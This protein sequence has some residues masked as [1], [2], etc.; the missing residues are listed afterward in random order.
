MSKDYT[1]LDKYKLCHRCE[2]A[3]VFP[4]RK[5]CPKCLEE[6]Q[7][8]AAAYRQTEEY[9]QNRAAYNARRSAKYY[10]RKDAGLCTVCGKPA[11][12]GGHYCY[13]HYI[14]MKRYSREAGENELKKRHERG[15]IPDYRKANHLCLRC[16]TPLEDG[17]DT[18]YCNFHRAQMSKYSFMADKTLWRLRS[19]QF[20]FGRR[21][22][23]PTYQSGQ[24]STR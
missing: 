12:H 14:R 3:K 8:R 24:A 17:N 11:T 7:N 19:K 10:Q 20:K 13:E 21:L 2:K 18:M 1:L 4:G 22:Y 9:A 6:M 15:L 5:F 23:E 16:G